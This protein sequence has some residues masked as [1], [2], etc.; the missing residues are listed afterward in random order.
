[1]TVLAVV[2]GLVLLLVLACW[3]E[4]RTGRAEWGRPRP[5]VAPPTPADAARTAKRH[6]AATV[7]VGAF[8]GLGAGDG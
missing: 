8:L 7:A 1:M 5:E 3:W 2:G 4:A 6:V